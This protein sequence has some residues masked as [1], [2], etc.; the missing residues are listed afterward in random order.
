MSAI[1]NI[2][3]EQFTEFHGFTVCSVKTGDLVSEE[4]VFPD[5]AVLKGFFLSE[6]GELFVD[7]ACGGEMFAVPREGKYLIQF[8]D[9]RYMRW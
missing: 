2:P 8:A 5:E 4:D 6:D 7:G 1:D 3:K 9:G